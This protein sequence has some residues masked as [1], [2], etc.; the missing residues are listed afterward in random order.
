MRNA[1]KIELKKPGWRRSLGELGAYG[2]TLTI[3][4]KG[5]GVTE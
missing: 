2:R 3:D 1:H 4:F 5:W